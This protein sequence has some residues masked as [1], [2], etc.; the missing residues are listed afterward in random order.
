MSFC[1]VF[2]SSFK[3][4]I[5]KHSEKSKKKISGGGGGGGGAF[6]RDLRVQLYQK[7]TPT[8]VFSCETCEI[9]KNTYSEEHLRM[10]ASRHEC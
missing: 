5:E 4:N 1:F 8:Q 3:N 7:E 6:I 2:T 9:F 10:T